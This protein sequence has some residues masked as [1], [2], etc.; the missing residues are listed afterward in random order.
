MDEGSVL[1]WYKR[2]G[3]G[4]SP[5][6]HPVGEEPFETTISGNNSLGDKN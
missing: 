2:E 5:S 4:L 6:F 3:L 1:N